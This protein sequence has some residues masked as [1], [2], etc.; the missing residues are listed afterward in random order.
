MLF[1]LLS[2]PVGLHHQFADPGITRSYKWLHAF[3]T[4]LVALP[5]FMTAFTVAASLEHA[6]RERGG[7]GLFA[8]WRRL[9]YFDSERYLFAYL[10]AGLVLFLFGGITGIINTSVAMNNV[11]HNTAWIPG[12]FHTTV[13]GPVFL[14]FLGMTL[15]LL[16]Q[17][18]GKRLRLP[19]LNL[20][21]PYLWTGG[22][23]VFS[24]GLSVAGL[25]GSPRRSNLGPTYANPD[26]PL[27]HPGWQFWS[28]LGAIGSVIMTLAMVFFFVVFFATLL[29]RREREPSLALPEA[30]AY[31][32]GDARYVLNFTP[33]VAAAIILLAIAYI[34]P[35]YEVVT[36]PTQGAPAYEPSSPV[37]ANP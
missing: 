36:G 30:E 8:W 21:V 35:L 33:W 23:L 2:A 20:W 5:S 31:H 4:F 17:L 11:V 7:S 26:S 28:H 9:P 15:L 22:V 10:F 27:F 24:F 3:L 6:A 18:T 14:G 32:D 29:G 34:P 19:T 13:G 16:T 12:H 1:I 37:V 25:L